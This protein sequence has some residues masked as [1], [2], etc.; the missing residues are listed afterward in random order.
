M[1]VFG[2]NLLAVLVAAISTIVGGFLWYS[3]MLFARPWTALMGYNPDDKAA[4]KCRKALERATALRS[5]SALFRRLRRLVGICCDSAGH[6]CIVRKKALQALRHRYRIPIGL[7]C[8]DGAIL[9][10]WPR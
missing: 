8:G 1:H 9:A 2:V 6:R 7:L 10:V 5:C 3:P 4:P